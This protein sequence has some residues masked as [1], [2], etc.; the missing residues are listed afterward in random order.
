MNISA[1]SCSNFTV[2][3]SSSLPQVLAAKHPVIPSS[4]MTLPLLAAT[5][6]ASPCSMVPNILVFIFVKGRNCQSHVFTLECKLPKA[7]HSQEILVHS[8]VL[9]EVCLGKISWFSNEYFCRHSFFGM[10]G[11][12]FIVW[13]NTFL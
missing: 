7:S 3:S 6:E 11:L 10:I 4:V 5:V 2:T 1:T 9:I 8:L 13:R 12:I